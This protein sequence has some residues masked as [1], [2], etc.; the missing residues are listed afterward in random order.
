MDVN[1]LA[2]KI[3]QQSLGEEPINKPNSHASKRGEARAKSLTPER[4]KSIA[5]K[6]AA[7]RWGKDSIGTIKT[8]G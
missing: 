4:R 5:Q 8:D 7:K 6:A 1:K 3:V 2:Y